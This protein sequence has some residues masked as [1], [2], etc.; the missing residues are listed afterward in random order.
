M[1]IAGGL[2]ALPLAP[3]FAA[4]PHAQDGDTAARQ[5]HH[6]HADDQIVVTGIRRPAGDVLGGVSVID[7]ADLARE[8]RPS[9]G[10]TLARQPGLSATS[11]GPTASRPIIRGLS[12]DRI[13]VL[14]DGIGS[15]DVSSSSADH[16]PA[17]NPLTAERIEVLRGPSALLFGS[18]AIGG[19][20]N[21]IDTRIPRREPEGGYD[22]DALLTYGTAAKERSANIAT[23]VALGSHWVGHVDGNWSKSDDQRTG[24]YLLSRGL[25]EQAAASPFEEVRDL[26]ALR[27]RLP[28]TAA[29]AKELAGGV[30]YVDGPLNIG[31][32]VTRHTALYGVPIR[33]SLNPAVEA[34]APRIDVEQTRYDMR[35]EVPLSGAFRQVRLRGGYANYRHDELEEDGAI[36]TSF[37][38]KGGEGRAELVQNERGGWGGTSGVQYLGRNVRIRGDEKFLPDSRQKQLGLFTMQT[39]ISGPVRLEGGARLEFSRLS[40]DQDDLLGT[41]EQSRRFRTLSLS[42]GGSYDLGSDWRAGLTLSRSARAPSI[43]ELF[44]NGPHAGTQAFEVGD[45]DLDPERSL[46]AEASLRRSEGPVKFT[47]TLYFSRFANF[48]YQ[49]PTGSVE[50]VLPVYSYRQGRAKYYG[51]ELEANAHLG[52]ALG[53][54][55]DGELVADATRATI[56]GYGPAPQIPPL[57]MIGALKGTIGSFDGRLEAEHAFR[58][59]RNADLET[60]TPAYT[61]VNAS[62]DWHPLPDNLGLTLSLAANNIF[63]VVARR[64]ASLL[65][66]YAPLAGRDVRLSA[67]LH[68]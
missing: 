24:G 57:R 68:L 52:K 62:V 21:V 50:E 12:G 23:S 14:T 6:D 64:H 48:I 1:L 61:L 39:L 60:E 35:A 58:Q 42:A 28:N 26:A 22:V 36:G 25:R 47:G 59:N 16:A 65:K 45:P 43:D 32:S 53:I 11:F 40:A 18:S 66:D 30:A 44:A 13:R 51:F 29:E 37:F 2:A 46:S 67:T 8:V 20:V 41:P 56:R 19:V 55:W 9:I 10:E 34:E 17:I 38:S 7:R 33:F 31:A 3:A 49:A 4:P 5:P 54:D 15:L 27:G 63:D